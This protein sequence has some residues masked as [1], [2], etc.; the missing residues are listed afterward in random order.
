MTQIE[1][2]IYIKYAQ[3]IVDGN[4]TACENIILACKRFLTWF[5]GDVMYCAYSEV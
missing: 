1:D 2:K 4:I 5:D 3:D